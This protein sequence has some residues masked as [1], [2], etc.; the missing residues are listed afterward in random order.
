MKIAP[1]ILLAVGLLILMIFGLVAFIAIVLTATSNGRIDPEESGPFIGGGCCC[2]F[3]GL[4]MSLGGLVW[5]L[6]ARQQKP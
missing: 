5:W 3:F 4:L 1:L 2:S 6:I